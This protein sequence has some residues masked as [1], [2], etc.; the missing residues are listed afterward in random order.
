MINGEEIVGK[1]EKDEEQ[2]IFLSHPL[3][4]LWSNQEEGRMLVFSNLMLNFDEQNIQINSSHVIM[5]KKLCPLY[6]EYYNEFL[7]LMIVQLNDNSKTH[8]RNSI[9]NIKKL[10]ETFMKTTITMQ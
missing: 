7:K 3:K 5:R 2:M 8:I 10:N 1:I 4:I 6:S 9:F